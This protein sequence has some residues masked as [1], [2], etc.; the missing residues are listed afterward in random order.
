MKSLDIKNESQLKKF[1]KIV[2]EEAYSKSINETS[3]P[4][5]ERY[6]DHY[7]GDEKL[8]GSLDEVDE[9]DPI[10]DAEEAPAEEPVAVD[11]DEEP[12]PVKTVSFDSIKK[13]I[14]NLRAGHSLKDS[15]TEDSLN[16]Y[17]DRLDDNERLIL[18]TFLEELSK[19]LNLSIK[20]SDAQ[21]PS[22]PPINMDFVTAEE[23]ADAAAEEDV[24][25]LETGDEEPEADAE[26]DTSPPIAVNESQDKSDLRR[27]I[28]ILMSK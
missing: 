9:E 5:K 18:H 1:L 2:A 23:E 10:E 16:V 12:E 15:E 3:D 26:E 19:I 21:D 13:A 22:E 11:Q 14:N 20:G 6:I 27:Q 7:K 28:R 17:Y 24:E 4:F 8:Y 25:N